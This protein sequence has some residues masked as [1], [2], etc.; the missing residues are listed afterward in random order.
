VSP[1]EENLKAWFDA[2]V[3]CVGMG[4]QLI[5]KEIISSKDFK[6]LTENVQNTLNLIKNIRNI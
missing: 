5:S 6:T 2:G 3:T 4:S 1:T